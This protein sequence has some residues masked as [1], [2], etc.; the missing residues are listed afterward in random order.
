MPS[1]AAGLGDAAGAAV[2]AVVGVGSGAVAGTT[3]GVSGVGMEWLVAGE[4]QC[5]GG[6]AVVFNLAFNV[7]LLHGFIGILAKA[8]CGAK[9]KKSKPEDAV[10][11]DVT[12]EKKDL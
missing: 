12:G 4:G 8:M 7:T 9:K 6:W 2:G 10:G 11:K 3:G 1:W 5:A